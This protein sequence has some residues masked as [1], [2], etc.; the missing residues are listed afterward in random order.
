MAFD[1][2]ITTSE[3]IEVVLACDPAVAAVWSPVECAGWVWQGKAP[4]TPPPSDATRVVIRPLTWAE[5]RQLQNNRPLG[6]TSARGG[7]L[8]SERIDRIRLDAKRKVAKEAIEGDDGRSHERWHADLSDADRIELE[9]FER[10]ISRTAE[11]RCAASVVEVIDGG[12][13]MRWGAFLDAVRDD[14]LVARIIH[15]AEIHC[16]RLSTLGPDEGK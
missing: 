12:V 6:A 7:E 1:L 13:S 11:A 2:K 4:K 10:E 8:Y 5:R 15:E 14:N 16:R 9:R 3:T